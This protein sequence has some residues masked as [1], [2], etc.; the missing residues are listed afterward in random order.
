VIEMSGG[1]TVGQKVVIAILLII[2]LIAYMAY[3]TYDFVSPSLGGVPFFYWYQTLWLAISSLL[4]IVAAVL[5][6]RWLS[7]R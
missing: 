4:F 3:T 2:P 5:W 6:E 7:R 1:L